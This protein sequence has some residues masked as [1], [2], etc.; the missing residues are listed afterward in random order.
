MALLQKKYTPAEFEAKCREYF[1]STTANGGVTTDCGLRLFLDICDSTWHSYTKDEAYAKT[2]EWSSKAVTHFYEKK[3][4]LDNKPVGAIFSLKATRGWSD[5]PA[6]KSETNNYV[7]VFGNEAK[8]LKQ[9]EVVEMAQLEQP[10]PLLT[11]GQMEIV[12]QEKK[13]R[14]RP[15]RK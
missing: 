14:G 12:T 11:T 3:L 8:Q 15:K 1:T 13:K 9:A 2:C 5:Q 10:N 7:Y 6:T 4:I